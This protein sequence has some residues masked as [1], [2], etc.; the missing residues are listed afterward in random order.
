MG[1]EDTGVTA[2][3]VSTQQDEEYDLD[4]E[5]S[6]EF[7][8]EYIDEETLTCWEQSTYRLQILKTRWRTTLA[9]VALLSL[10]LACLLVGIYTLS[11]GDSSRG[12]VF[13]I[14]AA[15]VG[16]PGGQSI[17]RLAFVNS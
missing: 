10:G 13:L 2:P 9:A 17:F 16:I 1:L 4:E 14:L 3:I 12:Y 5:T 7:E 6:E 15:L 11:Y 8:I